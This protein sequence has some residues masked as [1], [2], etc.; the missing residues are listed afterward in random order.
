MSNYFDDYFGQ[1]TPLSYI[2]GLSTH[3]EDSVPPTKR[4]RLSFD[5]MDSD[6]TSCE[7]DNSVQLFPNSLNFS[8][9]DQGGFSVASFNLCYAPYK[10]TSKFFHDE[11]LTFYFR[12]DEAISEDSSKKP[13]YLPHITAF[14]FIE[15]ITEHFESTAK[16]TKTP[17]WNQNT[18]PATSKAQLTSKNW[19]PISDSA[20]RG[21]LKAGKN[22]IIKVCPDILPPL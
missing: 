10:G 15:Y 5:E 22:T 16:T 1:E 4:R 6:V 17:L 14:D 21:W 20:L 3:L 19:K 12:D 8:W 2:N 9:I 7:E 13:I 11:L 18:L